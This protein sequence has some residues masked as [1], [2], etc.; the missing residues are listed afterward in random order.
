MGN[1]SLDYF[2]WLAIIPLLTAC[3][4]FAA[5]AA[6]AWGN[7]D[8]TQTSMR[9]TG[10]N[11]DPAIDTRSMRWFDQ[12]PGSPMTAV[13][14]VVHGLNLNPDRMANIIGVLN[15]S[16]IGALRVSLQ[17]HGD[18]FTPVNG[19]DDATARMQAFK[20]V[21]YR[22]WAQELLQAY[23]RAHRLSTRNDVPLFLVA[24]SYGALLALELMLSEPEVR[25]D[26][27]VLFAPALSMHG[28]NHIIRLFNFLPQWVWPSFSP[29]FY[30]AN[31]GTP[32]AAYQAVFE[33]LAR[34]EKEIGP[35]INIPTLVLIDPKDE[36]IS[37]QGLRE[38][39]KNQKLDQWR[40]HYITKD[41]ATATTRIHHLLITPAAVGRSTW[42]EMIGRM[43]NQL[44]K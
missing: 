43:Q 22:I 17:G 40:F 13:A 28:R 12:A 23:R 3:G 37:Y 11:G 5:G 24:H 18:N 19:M 38:L 25:F 32:Q 31:R 27:M 9:E 21:S 26:R 30:L 20:S 44:L 7:P 1:S 10:G 15:A 36:L 39:A 4:W 6:A 41:K 42:K 14:L 34:F 35:K 16:G 33:T 29:E 8:Q 2:R